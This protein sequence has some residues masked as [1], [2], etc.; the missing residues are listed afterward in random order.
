MARR[1]SRPAVFDR[2]PRASTDR[3]VV[4]TRDWSRWWA[5]LAVSLALMAVVLVLSG[6]HRPTQKP[7][8]EAA[9]RQRLAHPSTSMSAPRRSAERPGSRTPARVSTPT[10][11]TVATT[12]PAPGNDPSSG[13]VTPAT[14]PPTVASPTRSE[15]GGTG[16]GS[17]SGSAADPVSGTP[18]DGSAG[19]AQQGYLQPPD[20]TSAIYPA[21]AGGS[22]RVS[23]RWSGSTT[24]TLS[25]DCPDA[26]RSASGTSSVTVTLPQAE[27]DCQATLSEPSTESDTVSYTL[28]IGPDVET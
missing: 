19:D 5:V 23:A 28:S 7:S 8:A 4:P 6:G 1:R 15:A 9:A 21:T 17:G 26:A 14:T 11:T 22:L 2:T 27:G 18:P 10:S 16:S 13:S 24:L 12:P 20:N 25:V 3:P